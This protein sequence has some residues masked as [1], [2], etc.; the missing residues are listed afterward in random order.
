MSANSYPVP[1]APSNL[2]PELVQWRREVMQRII[3]QPDSIADLLVS[4][5]YRVLILQYRVEDSGQDAVPLP[6]DVAKKFNA[7][8]ATWATR[9]L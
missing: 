2:G 7:Q 1:E 8:L 9:S 5:M 4:L 3:T 6:A